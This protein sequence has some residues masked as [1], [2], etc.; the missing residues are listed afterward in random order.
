[1]TPRIEIASQMKQENTE[2]VN[3]EIDLTSSISRNKLSSDQ[4]T[5]IK[6]LT[7]QRKKERQQKGEYRERLMSNN[8][9]SEIYD[10]PD[11]FDS[12]QDSRRT[13]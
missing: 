7:E 5:R 2:N 12:D 9:K 11:M 10:E 6:Q 13:K 1:M 8:S 3:E 4:I